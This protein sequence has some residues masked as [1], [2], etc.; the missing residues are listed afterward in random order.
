M[1]GLASALLTAMS[2]FEIWGED[3]VDPDMAVKALEEVAS[4]LS[5]CS[6]EEIRLLARVAREHAESAR[7]AGSSQ[8]WVKF[9]ENFIEDVGLA[10][11]L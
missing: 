3:Y 8:A 7:A 9:Y 1:Q 5:E 11:R 4:D 10:D 2:Y 6:D